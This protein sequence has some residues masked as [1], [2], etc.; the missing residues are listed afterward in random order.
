MGEYPNTVRE[1][2]SLKRL[3][4]D[5]YFHGLRA[6]DLCFADNV[7]VFLRSDRDVLNQRSFE[8]RPHHRHV[9]IV[10]LQTPGSV[11]VDGSVYHLR[12]GEAFLIAPFQFHFYIGIPEKEIAWLF[13][14]F[15][16]KDPAPFSSLTNIPIPID[17]G[18][19]EHALSIARSYDQRDEDERS[20]PNE[21][22]LKVSSLLNTLRRRLDQSRA[23]ALPQPILKDASGSELVQKVNRLLHD[24]LSEGIGIGEL[25]ARLNLSDSHLRK[26]FKALTG[27]SLGSY[28][29]HYKLNRAVKLLVHSDATLTQIAIACGYE[30]LAAFSR[31]FKSKLDTS[32][33][34]YRRQGAR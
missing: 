22:V 4:P 21:L 32:P 8:N 10:N 28:L 11:S 26:R 5:D 2:R 12:A 29:V 34:H 1:L 18:L 25:A 23:T 20:D 13:I 6:S 15:D 16:A 17:A 9:L 33:S 30:S 14:T 24:R 27:L 19:A 31:S 7:V 3:L